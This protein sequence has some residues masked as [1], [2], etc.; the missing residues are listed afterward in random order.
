MISEFLKNILF[1]L[2]KHQYSFNPVFIIG[3]GR[4]GTTILGKTLSSHPEIKYLNERRDLWH[5]SYPEF[6]IWTDKIKN[7]KLFA[8]KDDIHA[9]KNILL[10]RLFFKE[11]VLGGASLLLEKLPINNFR[12][13]FLHNSFPDAK[14]IY[15]TRNGIEVSESIARIMKKGNWFLGNKIALLNQ[16]GKEK[17]FA[18]DFDNDIKLDVEKSMLEWRISIDES[19]AFF[20]KIDPSKFTHLSYQDFIE[21]TENSI[22]K[23]F[24]FLNLESSENI[25]KNLSKNVKRKHKSISDIKNKNLLKIGG[26][27]LYKTMDNTY[28]PI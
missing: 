28:S 14:Y 24:D 7:P 23:I 8:D 22:K 26:E 27:V 17:N 3:C 2:K 20:K 10:Q 16:F 11:Q 5:K 18:L 19:D 4:S 21:Q 25:L 9:Q 15:L 13:N 1:N 6:N 12:L